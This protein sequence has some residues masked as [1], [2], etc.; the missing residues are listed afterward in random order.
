[1][2]PISSHI[3]A[4][5]GLL[6]AGVTVAY[7]ADKTPAWVYQND[8]RSGAALNR[9]AVKAAPP[10]PARPGQTP[11]RITTGTVNEPVVDG[12]NDTQSETTVVDL[13]SGR[14]IAA[15]NDSGSSVGSANHFTGFATSSDFGVSWTDGGTLPASTEGDVGDPVLA[16]DR[17]TGAAYMVTL[18][19]TTGENLQVFKSTTFGTSWLPPVNATPGFAT[20]GDFQ[21]KPW[22]TVDN[23]SGAGQG[24]VYVCWTR[25]GAATEIRFTRSTDQGATFGP[26]Q[27]V[28]L[29]AG[30]QG[31]FVA[32]SPNHQ[33]NVFY[34]RGTGGGG[35]GGDNKLFLR[36][37][38]DGGQTFGTE[39]Q[40]ADLLTTSIN[41]NLGLAGGLRSNSFPH[42][43]I[44]PVLARPYIYVIFNDDPNPAS[45]TDNGNIYIVT[46]IDGGTTWS[47]PQVVN[48]DTIRDQFFPTIGIAAGGDQLMLAYYSR[49]RDQY[50]RMFHRRARL[51]SI[52]PVS[53][54][55]NFNSSFQL[56]P[57][58]P[59]AIGQDPAVN[60][61][62]MGDY[63]QI[64][65][66]SG[67]FSTTWS[68][69]RLSNSFHR[70][71]PDVRYARIPV[72]A[73]TGDLVAT[74]TATPSSIGLGTDTAVEVTVSA[75]GT[76]ARDVF[77][78]VM[79]VPGLKARGVSSPNGNCTI[80]FDSIDCS[81][82][83]VNIGSPKKVR[84]IYTGVIAAGSRVLNINATT[85][86]R[87]T[88]QANNKITRTITVTTGA[89]TTTT[90]QV[91]GPIPIP[92][93][94]TFIYVNLPV[95]QEGMVV[96]VIPQIRINHTWD[97]DLDISLISPAGKE[98]VLTSDNGGSSD[99]YG[100]GA[101]DCSGTFTRFVDAAPTS[102]TAGTAPFAGSFQPEEL[103]VELLAAPVDGG[104]K[105]RVRDDVAIDS[106]TIGCF[107]LQITRTPG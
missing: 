93:N 11:S 95:P 83:T 84:I 102:I 3:I 81:L 35:N 19:F 94:N 21:D 53:G 79:S 104:W 86:N 20:T 8:P 41:G 46:S 78:N 40:V 33:V 87:D 75:T 17:V 43:A 103:T 105:L 44:N 59:I 34:Y 99:N 85:S 74:S 69:N 91:S 65:G 82:G 98:I 15:F 42:V 67:V 18:G 76:S 29:S 73:P 14:L 60:A 30:G 50:N 96:N 72:P 16:Y 38:T 101:N 2:R 4:L 90:Y 63:D 107:S 54:V 66:G 45:A 39:V 68:D 64:F 6:L 32:V 62:Y 1:M 80:I 70:F 97:E 31:C 106:G 56:S 36:R 77:L 22:M 89:A 25:F 100:T 51:A 26:N 7:A 71:Q 13:G 48:D 12:I 5:T 61:V 57:N 9:D 23:F 47:S 52:T 55:L 10:A 49:S 27:G 37:S 88:N 92:D 28:L 58:T 24:N